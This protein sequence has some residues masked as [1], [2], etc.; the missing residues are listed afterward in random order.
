MD[1]F[2]K[3]VFTSCSL[4]VNYATIA[5]LPGKATWY[6]A[7]MVTVLTKVRPLTLSASRGIP[8]SRGAAPAGRGRTRSRASAI[9]AESA[10]GTNY[11]FW[12][13]IN[14]ASYIPPL[15]GLNAGSERTFML[16]EEHES[17]H[18]CICNCVQASR[19]TLHYHVTQCQFKADLPYVRHRNEAIGKRMGYTV[20]IFLG[21][22][23]LHQEINQCTYL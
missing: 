13:C 20:F 5:T 12:S 8:D 10:W 18:C 4:G 17:I 19:T 7:Y 15:R 22:E 16:K 6:V 14:H 9:F 3:L 11:E 23:S 2:L 21:V 1:L